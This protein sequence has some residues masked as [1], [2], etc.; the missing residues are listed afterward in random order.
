MTRRGYG[1]AY[2]KYRA[3][4]TEWNGR[5]FDSRAEARWAMYYDSELQAGRIKALEYQP[6]IELLPRPNRVKYVADFLLT[7]LDGS[8]EYVD[9]KGVVLPVFKLKMKL[10]KHFYPYVKLTIVK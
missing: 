4:K 8:K 9:V 7:H 2:S 6:V 10:L 3:V 5:K 1:P